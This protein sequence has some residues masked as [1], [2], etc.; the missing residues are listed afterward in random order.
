MPLTEKRVIII[1]VLALL[2]LSIVCV[3][4]H[5]QSKIETRTPAKAQTASA[6]LN[7]STNSDV[8]TLSGAVP[9]QATKT[10]LINSA[11]KVFGLSNVVDKLEVNAKLAEPIWV[12]HAKAAVRLLKSNVSNGAFVF[13]DKTVEVRG[14]ISGEDSK[15]KILR[16]MGSVAGVDLTVNDQLQIRTAHGARGKKAGPLQ[17]KLNDLL[18]GKYIEFDSSSSRLRSD[19]H[20]LLDAIADVLEA[21]ADAKIE[22]GGHTDSNG[23]ETK[24]VRLSQRRAEAVKKYLAG[25]GIKSN[26]IK[27]VGYGSSLPIAADSTF[28]GQRQNRR[29]EFQVQE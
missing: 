29:I 25:K 23:T 10:A 16:A 6:T 8:A 20:K 17:I 28:D 11:E 5:T 27:A 1:T 19:S 2:L 13:K 9:D 26:R 22:I 18:V 15:T 7:I 21:D 4:L 12:D 24:N 14:E 3:W